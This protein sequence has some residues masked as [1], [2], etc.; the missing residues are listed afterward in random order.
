MP[1][2]EFKCRKCGTVSEFLVGVSQEKVEFSCRKCG[3]TKL[4][5]L[6]SGGF[7]GK[8]KK[9]SHPACAAQGMCPNSACMGGGCHL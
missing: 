1:I 2:F 7:I 9:D 5:K 4:D 8:S 6:M 3:S